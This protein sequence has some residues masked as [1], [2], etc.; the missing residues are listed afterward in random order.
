M[1]ERIE[2][3]AD[4]QERDQS[5]CNPHLGKLQKRALK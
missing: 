4:E 5:R 1:E 3:I 2:K